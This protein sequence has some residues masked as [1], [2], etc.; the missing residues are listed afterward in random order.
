VLAVGTI[1]VELEDLSGVVDSGAAVFG[2]D[3]PA[4]G[5]PPLVGATTPSEATTVVGLALCGAGADGVSSDALAGVRVVEVATA[6]APGEKVIPDRTGIRTLVPESS[7][8]VAIST[9]DTATTHSGPLDQGRRRPGPISRLPG[10]PFGFMQAQRLFRT[11]PGG[12]LC[13]LLSRSPRNGSG[14]D[15]RVAPRVE[16]NAL[17]EDDTA[18]AIAVAAGGVE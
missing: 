13:A 11:A 10:V 15:M 1:V 16:G 4:E 2:I 5:F 18:H 17:R 12:P 7:V 9:T 8:A 14:I 3:C 6:R